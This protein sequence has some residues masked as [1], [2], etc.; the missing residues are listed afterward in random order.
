MSRDLLPGLRLAY[1]RAVAEHDGKA[2][3]PWKLEERAHFLDLLCAE[4]QPSPHRSPI[5]LLH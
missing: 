3:A 4:G 2:K 5:L 1:D